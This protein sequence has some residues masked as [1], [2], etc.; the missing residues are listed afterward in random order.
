MNYMEPRYFIKSFFSLGEQSLHI[1]TSRMV[2]SFLL[3]FWSLEWSMLQIDELKFLKQRP[4]RQRYCWS[5]K[6][7]F[8][9][10]CYVFLEASP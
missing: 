2:F 7:V 8:S 9:N 6:I 10:K 4:F 5:K 3:R 1:P